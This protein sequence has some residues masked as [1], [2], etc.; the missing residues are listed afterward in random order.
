MP[1]N[2]AF[3]AWAT[4]VETQYTEKHALEKMTATERH[5]LGMRFRSD[6]SDRFGGEL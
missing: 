2:G 4:A 6:V 1:N 5:D 3:V